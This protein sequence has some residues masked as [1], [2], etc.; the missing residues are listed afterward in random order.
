[1]NASKGIADLLKRQSDALLALLTAFEQR[2]AVI[3]ALAG[4]KLRRSTP[5]PRAVARGGGTAPA[6]LS[7]LVGQ[8]LSALVDEATAPV[9][10]A[11]AG[12]SSRRSAR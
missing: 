10:H 4:T 3:E 1:L 8:K 5:R 11:E 2:L 12:L 9:S 7:D 6:V